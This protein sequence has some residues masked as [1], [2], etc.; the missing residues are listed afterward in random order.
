MKKEREKE[1]K[2]PAVCNKKRSK[3]QDI[4]VRELWIVVDIPAGERQKMQMGRK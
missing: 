2:V 1:R 4:A 3:E